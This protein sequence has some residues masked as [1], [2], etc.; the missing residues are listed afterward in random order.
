MASDNAKYHSDVKSGKLNRQ[1]IGESIAI[2][3]Q[4]IICKLSQMGERLVA[5]HI[6]SL[7][8][9]VHSSHR[10]YGDSGTASRHKICVCCHQA[11]ETTLTSL[12]DNFLHKFTKFEARPGN[13]IERSPSNPEGQ[14]F[15]QECS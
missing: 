15:V 9:T 10:L 12:G 1:F 2:V 6:F 11:S 3:L 7:I 8:S 14:Y 4:G 5:V 13:E